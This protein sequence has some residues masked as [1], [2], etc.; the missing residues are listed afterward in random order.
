[1]KPK[2]L[3][4]SEARP[5]LILFDLLVQI[6]GG[7]DDRPD[8]CGVASDESWIEIDELGETEVEFNHESD[9]VL[10]DCVAHIHAGSRVGSAADVVLKK[11]MRSHPPSPQLGYEVIV[12]LLIVIDYLWESYV[13]AGSIT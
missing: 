8:L 10:E 11:L 6:V 9:L 3:R 1:M 2:L 12:K 7:K 4:V 13:W 5:H